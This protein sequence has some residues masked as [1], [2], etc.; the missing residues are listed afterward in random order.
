MKTIIVTIILY[1]SSNFIFCQEYVSFPTDSAKWAGFN[2]YQCLRQEKLIQYKNNGEVIK[3]GKIYNEL[4]TEEWTRSYDNTGVGYSIENQEYYREENKKIYF[5]I[6]DEEVLYYDFNLNLKDTFSIWGDTLVVIEVFTQF[7]RRALRLQRINNIY[8]GADLWIT[9]VEGIGSMNGLLFNR[10]DDAFHNWLA[11]FNHKGFEPIDCGFVNSITSIEEHLNSKY[12]FS[13]YPNP[14]VNVLNIDLF[15]FYP[16]RI[17][18]RN[19]FG[20]LLYHKD[21]YVFN[22]NIKIDLSEFLPGLYILSI[23]SRNHSFSKKFLKQ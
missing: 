21:F 18:I 23:I 3:N 9:W 16:E 11:C 7:D 12:N 17:E 19:V 6:N 14:V 8:T 2:D 1:F 20:Q 13:I 15:K 10:P 5:L 22:N 4:Y